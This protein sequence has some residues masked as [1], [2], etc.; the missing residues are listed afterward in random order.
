[1]FAGYAHSFPAHMRLHVALAPDTTTLT[2]AHSLAHTHTTRTPGRNGVPASRRGRMRRHAAHAERRACRRR[3]SGPT[4]ALTLRA[5]RPHALPHTATANMA[6]PS[7]WRVSARTVSCAVMPTA[8]GDGAPNWQCAWRRGVAEGRGGGAWRRGVAEGRGG[9]SCFSCSGEW[10]KI[11]LGGEGVIGYPV[12][13]PTYMWP[14]AMK[15]IGPKP[16]LRDLLVSWVVSMRNEI[17]S[18]RSE[19]LLC[20]RSLRA[21]LKQTRC[22]GAASAGRR[23]G[24][25][26]QHSLAGFLMEDRIEQV[27][28]GRAL[29][30]VT[31]RPHRC[32]HPL[33]RRVVSW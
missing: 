18:S 26:E 2:L 5:A 32:M 13:S 12:Y 27:R 7:V 22:R 29:V 6:L 28:R 33:W 24:R 9:N 4:M 19:A 8:I 10:F 3:P 23:T 11:C 16:I 17:L 31:T 30:S 15:R 25:Q 21:Y 20:V 14:T 1:M